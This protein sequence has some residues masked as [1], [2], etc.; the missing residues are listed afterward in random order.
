[1][2]LP[3]NIEKLVKIAQGI[4]PYWATW[5]LYAEILV[6]FSVL[7]ADTPPCTDWGEI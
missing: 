7:G 1:M 3:N 6:K 4:C 2:K 5:R